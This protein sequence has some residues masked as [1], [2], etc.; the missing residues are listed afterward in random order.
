MKEKHYTSNETTTTL[1]YCMRYENNELS[2]SIC[3]LCHY[4]KII[5][6]YYFTTNGT[7]NSLISEHDTYFHILGCYSFHLCNYDC[8]EIDRPI[9]DTSSPTLFYPVYLCS[10]YRLLL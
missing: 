7:Q 6:K 10:L 3:H 1:Q 4:D 9:F 2:F 8:V 5:I